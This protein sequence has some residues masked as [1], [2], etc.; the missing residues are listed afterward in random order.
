M[1]EN[2]TVG[3]RI[4]KYD[5]LDFTDDFMFCKVLENNPAICQELAELITGRKISKIVSV[6]QQKPIRKSSDGKGVRFD[7][8]FTDDDR[9]LYDFEMQ[10]QVRK[11]LPRRTRYYQSMIDSSNLRKSTDYPLLPDSYIVFICMEDPYSESFYKYTF[12]E[13]CTEKPSLKMGDGTWKIFINANGT[14]GEVSE[15]LK[16]FLQYLVTKRPVNQLTKDIEAAVQ[17][18]RSDEEWRN[19]YMTLSEMYEM[20]K[21]DGYNTGVNMIIDNMIKDNFS[22][23]QISKY[24]G[25]SEEYIENRR[26]ELKSTTVV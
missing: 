8:Y 2:F 18:A 17:E 7:V 4:K 6:E 13:S 20:Y 26:K 12:E 9:R 10:N 14:V 11:N 1:S 19:D 21:E 24:C 23:T 22:N 16:E 5:E 3:A 25:K 15:N